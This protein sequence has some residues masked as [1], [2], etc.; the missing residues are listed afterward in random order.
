MLGGARGARDNAILSE[1]G[2]FLLLCSR[3]PRARGKGGF[4]RGNF[5]RG[6]LA[7]LPHAQAPIHPGLP[8]GGPSR[9]PFPSP[10]PGATCHAAGPKAVPPRPHAVSASGT[11]PVPMHARDFA[12]LAL[13][14]LAIHLSLNHDGPVSLRKVSLLGVGCFAQAEIACEREHTLLLIGS[15]PHFFFFS[16][17]SPPPRLGSTTPRPTPSPPWRAARPTS[18]PRP[19]PPT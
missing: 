8:E 7:V 10:I 17:P 12:A 11:R 19:W 15:H 18:R 13:S 9:E 16:L 14:L 5:H 6:L 1:T 2:F 4:T 3:P